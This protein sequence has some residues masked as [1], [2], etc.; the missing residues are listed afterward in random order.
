MWSNF[1]DIINNL[2][3]VAFNTILFVIALLCGIVLKLMSS[4]GMRYYGKQSDNY[5]FF[6]SLL[7]RLRVPINIFLPV[8]V[9]NMM[10]PAMKLDEPT[11]YALGK[12]IEVLIIISFAWLLIAALK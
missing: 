4:I 10:L 2:S 6:R 11:T 12:A 8:V 7:V 5:S 9:I 3:P 1:P